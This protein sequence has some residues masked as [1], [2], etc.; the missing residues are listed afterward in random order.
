M[1]PEDTLDFVFASAHPA[2]WYEALDALL[3]AGHVQAS[4]QPTLAEQLQAQQRHFQRFDEVCTALTTETAQRKLVA[5]GLRL[6][7]TGPDKPAISD[8]DFIALL[9]HQT[10]LV[11]QGFESNRSLR[12]Q[13][14]LQHGARVLRQDRGDALCGSYPFRHADL[15]PVHVQ[16]RSAPALSRPSR[17]GLRYAFADVEPFVREDLGDAE[18]AALYQSRL[19]VQTLTV[20]DLLCPGEQAL[21]GQRGVFARTDIP[22]GVCLGVYGGQILDPVDI[23]LLE[24][25]SYIYK[26]SDTPGQLCVNG[27][28][29][30]S[31]VNTRFLFDAQGRVTGHPRDV[32]NVEDAAFEV[33]MSDQREM[34]MHAYFSIAPIAAGTELR[35]CYHL[36]HLDG[37]AM[38]EP[39]P[40]ADTTA[41]TSAQAQPA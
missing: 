27:E 38:F 12:Q 17:S 32:Y 21:I 9:R 33:R 28:I 2:H 34:L 4:A 40:A 5:A 31:L 23:F 37:S 3:Q 29:M 35:I 16:V 18:R 22:A 19:R 36:G 41:R 10:G 26:A 13:L 11:R 20:H 6:Y 15:G 39:E 7:S 24:D 8:A 14:R 30:T 1:N 25:T